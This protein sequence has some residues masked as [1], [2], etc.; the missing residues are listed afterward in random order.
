MLNYYVINNIVFVASIVQNTVN[1]MSEERSEEY[2]E[3]LSFVSTSLAL[4]W[5]VS[6]SDEC[7]TVMLSWVSWVD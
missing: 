5:R 3:C 6:L 7:V 1:L 2:G 4:L